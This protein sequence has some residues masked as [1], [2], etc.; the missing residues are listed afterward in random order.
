MIGRMRLAAHGHCPC[1][2][3]C[4]FFLVMGVH[5]DEEEFLAFDLG[6]RRQIISLLFWNR[7]IWTGLL[8][9]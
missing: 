5:K 7:L 9:D 3:A 4:V 6:C 2:R 8:A 1:I